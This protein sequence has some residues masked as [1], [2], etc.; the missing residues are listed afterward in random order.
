INEGFSPTEAK[1]LIF[2]NVRT[3]SRRTIY[4]YLPDECKDKRM[5]QVALHKRPVQFCT[6]NSTAEK[7]EEDDTLMEKFRSK[8]ESRRLSPKI[9]E[10]SEMLDEKDNII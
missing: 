9:L 2:Q 3:I 10:F 8:L 6:E 4:Y 1:D 5:Q 7:I